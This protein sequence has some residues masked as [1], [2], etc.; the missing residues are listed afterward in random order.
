MAIWHCPENAGSIKL[1]HHTMD[2]SADRDRTLVTTVYT[3]EPGTDSED[4]LKLLAS[5]AAAHAPA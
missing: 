4:R 1:T 5:W 3:A 2:I